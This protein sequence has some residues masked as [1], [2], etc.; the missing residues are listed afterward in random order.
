MNWTNPATDIP[1]VGA[2]ASA[3]RLM[4]KLATKPCNHVENNINKINIP[5]Y[6]M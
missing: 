2:K 5:I 4:K 1:I 6:K 3:P